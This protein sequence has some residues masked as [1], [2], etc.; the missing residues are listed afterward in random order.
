MDERKP[1]RV[2][3]IRISPRALGA[4]LAGTVLLSTL[5]LAPMAL[6]DPKGQREEGIADDDFRP[7]IVCDESQDPEWRALNCPFQVN[8]YRLYA[9][10]E[11]LSF[12]ENGRVTIAEIPWHYYRS[13]V[14]MVFSIM[15]TAL[16]MPWMDWFVK[17]ADNIS[18]AFLS[19]LRGLDFRDALGVPPPPPTATEVAAA[20]AGVGIPAAAAAKVHPR[21]GVEG[22]WLAILAVVLFIGA[23]KMVRPLKIEKK[24]AAPD[25]GSD[26]TAGLKFIA[27]GILGLALFLVAANWHGQNPFSNIRV[28]TLFCAGHLDPIERKD[29]CVSGLTRVALLPVTVIMEVA[30]TVDVWTSSIYDFTQNEGGKILFHPPYKNQG[31][32]RAF[33][34]EGRGPRTMGT[35]HC[36]YPPV[37][38]GG[39][40]PHQGFWEPRL[41]QDSSIRSAGEVFQL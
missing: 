18:L 39:V 13:S 19:L 41:G 26:I 30:A 15:W 36:H 32:G 37:E 21:V 33:K 28:S 3:G 38:P 2:F 24:G 11:D 12:L 17:T 29:G 27:G 23:W 10:Y 5:N 34:E 31:R 4:L 14:V 6:A 16:T 7:L 25:P 22:W 9:D 8:S 20:T 35:L 40:G 1:T